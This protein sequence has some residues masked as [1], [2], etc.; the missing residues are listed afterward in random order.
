MGEFAPTGISAEGLLDHFKKNKKIGVVDV[1]DTDYGEFGVIKGAIHFPYFSITDASIADLLKNTLLNHKYD[2]LVCYCKFGRAR[3]V[4]AAHEISK[5][6]RE[7]NKDDKDPV[8]F[9]KG[10]ITTFVM[11]PGTKEYL[12]H[13]DSYT[14]DI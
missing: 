13:T 12:E 7:L 5:V 8:T 1:R 3:S 11:T 14:F 4:N 9:L 6:A 10:G 2:K